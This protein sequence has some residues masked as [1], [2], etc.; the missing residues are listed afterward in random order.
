VLEALSLF[1]LFTVVFFQLIEVAMEAVDSYCSSDDEVFFG[2]I[3]KKEIRKALELRRRTK[4][5]EPVK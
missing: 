4:V 2:P 1:S 5:Y 3:T